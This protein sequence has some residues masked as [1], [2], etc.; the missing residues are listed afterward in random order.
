MGNIVRLP[1]GKV[2]KLRTT[3]HEA[4]AMEFVRANTSI[5][6]PNVYKIY[7]QP[8]AAVHILMESLPGGGADYTNMSPEQVRAFGEEL[9]GYLNQPRS[10]EP[11]KKGFI[12]SITKEALHDHRLGSNPFGPFN[13]VDHFHSYLR[14][15]GSLDGWLYDPIVK[16]VHGRSEAYSVKFTHGDL[17]PS[18]IQ[19]KN[20]KIV[21][22]IDWETAGWYPEYW[23]YTKM[24]FATRPAYKKFYEAV[25]NNPLIDNYHEELKAERDIWR[26]LSPWS[27]DD[28]YGDPKNDAAFLRVIG[29]AQV[30]DETLETEQR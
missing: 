26:R 18:N 22:I 30:Q 2:I 28:F 21:G 4:E 7:E 13:C 27:Y 3:R 14:L 11:P 5:P 29:G 24:W 20:G 16:A 9:S 25:E 17:N 8:D 19:C 1:F 6:L 15:G 23:E 10:L 12:G